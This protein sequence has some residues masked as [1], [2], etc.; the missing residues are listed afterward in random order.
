[1]GSTHITSTDFAVQPGG[2]VT[3][4]LTERIGVRLAADYRTIIDWEEGDATY[5][6]EFRVLSGFS[7]HW[8]G[9]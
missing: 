3:V 7:L 8:G 6:H 5:G 2:G 1:V 9:R 4:L